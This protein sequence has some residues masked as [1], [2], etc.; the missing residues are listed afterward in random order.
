MLARFAVGTL[1]RLFAVGLGAS[2]GA[3]YYLPPEVVPSSTTA[4]VNKIEGITELPNAQT[5]R[6][7]FIHGIGEHN[8]C[9][10]DTLLL[11]LS[12]ALQVRQSPPSAL[13]DKAD[14][15]SHFAI[16]KPTPM[17]GAADAALLYKYDFLGNSRHL[18][19]SFLLWSPLTQKLKETLD[20]P[21][22]PHHA[23]LASLAKEFEQDNLADVVLYGGR[24]R[25]VIRPQ[26]EKALCDFIG[27]VPGDDPRICDNGTGDIPTAIVTHSLGGYMLMDAMADIYKRPRN[28]AEREAR[29]AAEKVG[30]E[31]NLIFML[32]NQLKMLDLSTKKSE[33]GASEV[34]EGFRAS[35]KAARRWGAKGEPEAKRQLVAISDPND[36]LS[37][38]VTDTEFNRPEFTVANVYLGTTGEFFGLYR[39]PIAPIAAL[40]DRAHLNY[41]KDD[42]VMDIIV[43]GMTGNTINRCAP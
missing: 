15:Q 12:K 16:P 27:G 14:C 28:R 36:I 8:A 30:R 43:C 4:V 11:H 26:V 35:W 2:A 33:G 17:S 21:Q 40:P 42:D 37:W 24:Y 7:L 6:I 31:L 3:C 25:E 9:D 29:N 18:K 41:L 19:F 39:A 1:S 20:E 13:D 34:V 32:A 10:P 23:L 22:L 5:I 38:E